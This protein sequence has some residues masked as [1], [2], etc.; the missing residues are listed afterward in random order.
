MYNKFTISACCDKFT[1]HIILLDFELLQLGTSSLVCVK[2]SLAPEGRLYG[3]YTKL[4]QKPK[5]RMVGILSFKQ[6]MKIIYVDSLLIRTCYLI[7]KTIFLITFRTTMCSL[8]FS[9]HYQP[10]IYY[11]NADFIEWISWHHSGV[12]LKKCSYLEIY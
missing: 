8:D 9:T 10:W 12:N 3:Y 5:K 1:R 7:M 4:K 6:L 2:L 11:W